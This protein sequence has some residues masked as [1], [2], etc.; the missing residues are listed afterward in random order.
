[1]RATSE[2]PGRGSEF[3]VRLPLLAMSGE[4]PPA[5]DERPAGDGRGGPAATVA[6]VVVVEDNVDSAEMLCELLGIAGY[7]CDTAS[8]GLEGLATIERVR[9]D[10]AFVDVGLPGMDGHELAR[11]VRAQRE[12][13][14]VYLVA[15]TGYGQ[16]S[17]RRRALD[18]G[19][20]EHLV[21]PV[22]PDKV[23]TLLTRRKAG[24]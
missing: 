5:D 16:S 13:D 8:N 9:P 3:E 2:G 21:K 24:G 22:D 4:L 6:R 23:M 14:S 18:A 12:L 19:F 10:V 7:H 20:D 1:M 17:D 15:L 11:R